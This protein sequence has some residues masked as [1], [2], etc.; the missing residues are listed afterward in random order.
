M[1]I[2]WINHRDPKHPQAG[3]AEVYLHEVGK[4]LVKQGHEIILLAERFPGSLK[5]EVIDGIKVRRM[6][7]KYSMHAYALYYT[8]KHSNEYDILIDDIA[9]AV[10][11]WSP[12]VTKKPV[13]A[14]VMHV[15][16][17]VVDR[18]LRFPLNYFVKKAE[19]SIKGTYKYLIAISEKTKQDLVREFRVNEGDIKVIHCGVDHDAYTSG[20][21]FNEPT[22][23][24][25][26]RIKKYKNVDHVIRAF[27][28]VKKSVKD[29]RLV[30]TGSGEI[31]YEIRNL[32][33]SMR[34]NDI[35]FTGWVD[36]NEKIRLI[37][38]SWVMTCVSDIEGWSIGVLEA[39]ACGTPTI[40]YDVGALRE[41]VKDGE[42]GLLARYG[43]IDELTKKLLLIL[44]DRDLRNKLSRGALKN[45]YNF[46]WDE[47]AQQ[48]MKVCKGVICR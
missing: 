16:Q 29:V 44:E 37:Q 19:R 41:S 17:K 33:A 32:V 34:L 28:D 43:N 4:R 10:P 23:L 36:E 2:L 40:A 15:H 25:M 31:E 46:N 13:V 39:A 11:F 1:R 30:I 26:G 6:G 12:H 3:G 8:K 7:G 35:V 24:W 22:I 45:S 14:L 5:E 38:G 9:H 20:L 48:F 47:C 27:S 18:E 42:T 21:K